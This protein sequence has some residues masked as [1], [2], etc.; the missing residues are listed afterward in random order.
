MDVLYRCCCGLDVHAKTLVACLIIAG[1]KTVRTF[2]TMTEDILA[3]ADW[4]TS[5]GCTHIAMESTGVYWKP[6]FNILEGNFVVVLANAQHIKNVPGRKTDVKDCEW[7]AELLRHG[8]I[9]ASFIPP[10]PIRELRE[11]TRYRQNLVEER[12]RLANRIQKIAESGNIKLSQV[13]SDALGVSGRA[14]LG[15]IAEGETDAQALAD[16]ARQGLRKKLPDLRRALEGRLTPA[17][18]WV[19]ADLLYQYEQ[20]ETSVERVSARIAQ[21]VDQSPDPTIRE[22]IVLLDTIPGIALHAAEDI[23]AEI[24]TQM[25]QF[26]SSQRLASWAGM[27]PGNNESA[28]KRKSGKT[29]KG[30]S[31]LRRV[32]V[33]ASWASSRTKNTSLGA[34][35]HRLARRLGNKKAS[36]AV[37]HSILVIIYHMLDR[38][39]PYRELGANYYDIN[40]KERTQKRLVGKL[41][42]LGFAVHLEPKGNAA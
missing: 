6:V 40:D 20:L 33:Q 41:E 14:M 3:L 39:E 7:I 1:K 19:L 16:L 38:K 21:E 8:L 26:G 30:S 42:S 5:S 25:S 2:S 31:H 37:G 34:Q 35:Y 10:M 36:V 17:Q 18:R 23:V 15:A 24:G 29:T 32:L 4:L 11:L 9:T 27:C 22:A 12:A 13:A 28:G